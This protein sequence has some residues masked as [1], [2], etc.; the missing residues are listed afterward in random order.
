[1][2]QIS[3]KLGL[4]QRVLPEYR[5]PFFDTLAEVCTKGLAVFAGRG[6]QVEAI[7]HTSD[8]RVAEYAAANNLHMLGGGFYTCVQTNLM[9]WLEEWQ[10]E[11]LIVEANPRNLSTPQA[12]RWMHARKRPVIGWGL[13]APQARGIHGALRYRFLQSLDGIIAYSQTGA[14]QYRGAGCKVGK[15]FVAPNAVTPR[16]ARPAIERPANFKDGR[17]TVVFVGRLQKRKKLDILLEACAGLPESLKPRLVIVGDGPERECLQEMA[18]KVYPQA[19]LVGPKF[20]EEL[21]EYYAMADLFVLPGTGGLAVQQAMAHSLPVL[22]GEADG[23]QGELVREE[24]GWLIEEMTAVTLRMAL[25]HALQDVRRLRQMGLAS[26]RI[27]SE[28]VNLERMVEAFA[29]AINSVV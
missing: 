21:W 13:G 22:V 26:Y 28:E 29:E 7:A 8:L 1:M 15:V 20:G 17:A 9:Q 23:T 2:T 10:P 18:G 27:V 16:P 19:E 5:A 25:E 4:Q 24:N 3:V 11:V 6:R 14:E 12:I